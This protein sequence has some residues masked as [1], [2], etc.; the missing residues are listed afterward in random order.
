MMNTDNTKMWC[1]E[2][3]VRYIVLREIIRGIWQA[4]AIQRHQSLHRSIPLVFL[5]TPI[6]AAPSARAKITSDMSVVKT[7]PVSFKVDKAYLKAGRPYSGNHKSSISSSIGTFISKSRRR[8]VHSTRRI[9]WGRMNRKIKSKMKSK[10]YSKNLTKKIRRLL[11][12]IRIWRKRSLC[13]S[14]LSKNMTLKLKNTYRKN[15]KRRRMRGRGRLK[16]T[17]LPKKNSVKRK[18]RG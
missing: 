11:K 9:C 1:A 2:T 10:D 15:C 13:G 6:S 14:K 3:R 17:I 12:W 18:E 16:N 8:G 7:A 5:T 4:S